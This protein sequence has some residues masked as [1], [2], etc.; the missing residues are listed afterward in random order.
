M[1]R[2][3]KSQLPKHALRLDRANIVGIA[4]TPAALRRALKLPPGTLDAIELRLDAIE[5]RL[6]T[7]DSVPDPG[8][9]RVPVIATVRSPKEGGKNNLN[10]RERASRYLALLDRVDAIDI[11]LASRA[12]MKSV[13]DAARRAGRRIIL[14]FHDFKGTPS[15]LRAL[16]RKASAAGADVF[17]IAVTPRTAADFTALLELLDNPPL[18]TSVMGMGPMGRASRLAAI[19]C[20]SVLNYG[21]IERPNAAGQWS[22]VELR[23]LSS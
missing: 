21:W 14:S 2:Q 13:L 15:G 5:L 16:Q 10:A 18:P 11:E 12:E 1:T 8:A 6:D 9:L 17:K 19:A 20:G 3:R 7:F 4:D 22:A 23:R